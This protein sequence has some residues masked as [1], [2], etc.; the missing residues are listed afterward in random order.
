MIERVRKNMLSEPGDTTYTNRIHVDDCAGVLAHMVNQAIRGKIESLYL[1]TDCKPC[2]RI[3]LET[4]LAG[5]LGL[6]DNPVD[7]ES[8]LVQ[9]GGAAP[10][11][12]PPGLKPLRG[13]KRIAGSKRCSNSRLLQSGYEFI[14]P[15]YRS[16]YR[17][18]LA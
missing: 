10:G 7:S 17:Q 6:V 9:P 3:E 14:Y 12:N 5:E 11:S 4:F 18:V 16:G 2:T 13:G 15:D 8:E 1:A